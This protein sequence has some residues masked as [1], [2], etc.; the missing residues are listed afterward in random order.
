MKKIVFTFF[1]VLGLL[2]TS[3][4]KKRE[5]APKILVFSKTMGF[6]HASIPAGAAAL[7]K[8][9]LEN[10][11]EV[12]TTKNAELFTEENLKQY[13]AVVFLSTTGNVLDHYQEA[14]FERYI[15]AGGGYV[16][17][18]AATDTEYDWGWYNKLAGAYFH[19]HPKGTPEAD[20]II[21][22]PNFIAT[23]FFTDSIW[24]RKDE[25]YNYRKINPDVNVILT[26]D[27]STY[28][29]GINGKNH[30]MAWYH[31]YDGGRA[32]YTAGGHTNESFEEEMFL[33][34]VLGGIQYAIGDNE[35]LD[36]SKV[37]SQIPPEINRFSKETL[38]LGKFFEPTEMTILPNNDVL[39]AQR[40][41]EIML[42]KEETKE[43]KQ[44][45]FLDVYYKALHTPGVNAE[46][47]VMGLQKDP[48]F[49]TNNWVYVFYSPTGD[50]WINRLSRFKFKD[51]VFDLES[52]QVILD[53]DS[54][55]EICCHT[56]GSIT[57]GPDKLLYLSTGDNSTPFNEKGVKYTNNGFAPLNNI[58]GKQQYDARRSSGN[59]N[60]LRGKILRIKVKEDGS[61]SIPEG[62]LFAE[63]TAKT[64]P[65][66]YTMGHRNPY[67]I[68]VDQKRKYL[69]WG[70]VG[71]DA[72]KNQFAT[73]GP[74]GYDEVNQAKKAGNFG[75][76]FFVADNQAYREY[77]YT[78]GESG[79]FFDT[80][81]PINNSIN[82]TGLK[83]LPEA[84]PAFV[85]YPYV[86][87]N[88]FPQVGSGGRNAMAGPTYYSD[89]YEGENELPSYY[90]G[91]VIIYDWMRGW[92]KA[93]TLFDNG[94][95][96]KMEPFASDVEV[97]SLIDMEVGPNGRL[98]LLEYGSG[99][100]SQNKNSSLGYIN[101][102]GGNRPPLVEGLHID[103][104][105]G[106]TP[107][108]I[109]ATVDAKD[110]EKDALTYLWTF[111]DG[112]TKET[113]DP[114]VTY[115]YPNVGDYKISVQV[116]DTKDETT[117]SEE[118]TIVAGNTRPEVTIDLLDSNSTFYTPGKKVAYNVTVT[119]A[120]GNEDINP[121]NIFVSVDYL[122]GLDKVAMS[123]GHQQVSAA[124][125][126]KA[127]TQSMDCKA[128]HKE[129]EAS[130]GPMY[131]DVAK[132]YKDNKNAMTYLQGKM[133]SGGTGVWGEVTMPAHPNITS[134]ETSQIAQ[135]ILS[136]ANDA[137]KKQSL[138]SKGVIKAENRKPGN[139]L[140]LTASYTD[141]GKNGAIPLTGTKT[142]VLENNNKLVQK[143]FV[144]KDY[145][146]VKFKGDEGIRLEKNEGWFM[147]ENIDLK[148]IKNIVISTA[149]RA[150]P[151]NAYTFE[152]HANEPDGELLGEAVMAQPNKAQSYGSVPIPLTK[153]SEVIK[154]L[155][156]VCKRKTN[157]NKADGFMATMGVTFN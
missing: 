86:E 125:T 18:H 142:I 52:E 119:D 108:Q 135:Y 46:E 93:V 17:I 147:L 110:L 23:S 81:K 155:Y 96:N 36:Y 27:E 94:D 76:P 114:E 144:K 43:L 102:N 137:V 98:Y 141:A 47:G 40:R 60:D 58:E 83:E 35:V 143:S 22:D 123:L 91:K 26:V 145:R 89:M 78:T 32:F 10:G 61:Y 103:K 157:G 154:K 57:F 124:V 63:G 4:S 2:I 41:G 99:W 21:K 24:H 3:C 80:K 140:V 100:F 122:E 87:S 149:W 8:L 39:I 117:N 45:A 74:R 127:L 14:A 130:I 150:I 151:K 9:G 12:D 85:Y 11:I 84:M 153:K 138:P 97:N 116:K 62:N 70:E 42:F 31:E 44:V 148:N 67:R 106:K 88:D 68:S 113:K 72:G 55:R 112:K 79:N 139:M 118:I 69:Y 25:L 73:R 111:G 128:C 66:I 33:K 132:K 77:D 54:Q 109:T 7:Q 105:S 53:V 75:W 15:Q 92:M 29:G 19:S 146:D 82:N 101:Y 104:T 6:K 56:G 134:D 1:M 16:G 49:A 121:D 90:D 50:K 115:I 71:P 95:F 126:G 48:D 51:D 133:K 156:I 65:E 5:G 30:P 64:R 152:V 37:T 129:A 38:S 13:A 136:L 59:T 20:F 131:I 34:H 120:D 107:L 28:E